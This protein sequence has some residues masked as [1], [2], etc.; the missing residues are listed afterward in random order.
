MVDRHVGAGSGVDGHLDL[1]SRICAGDGDDIVRAT[2]EA[3]GGHDVEGHLES[4]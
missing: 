4:A 2:V 3:R 1:L